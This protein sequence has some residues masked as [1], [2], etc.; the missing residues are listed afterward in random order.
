[1]EVVFWFSLLIVLYTYI[2]YGFTLKICSLFRK[3]KTNPITEE[4]SHPSVAHIVACYN[5]E[6]IIEEKIN[7]CLKLAYPKTKLNTLFVTDGSNDKTVELVQNYQNSITH[8]HENDRKGKLNAVNRVINQVESDIV[9]FSDAN[10]IL[11]KDA[12][13]KIS[14]AFRDPK[15]GAVSGEKRISLEV[16]DDASSS[17]ES[18]YWKYESTLKQLESKVNTVIGAAGELFAIRKN[19]YVSPPSNSLI[20]D[21]ITSVNVAKSGYRVAYEPEA[22]AVEKGSESLEEELKRKVRISAGGIQSIIHFKGL[23]NPIKYGML[24][25]QYIS[26]RV[27]RWT[28]APISLVALFLSNIFLADKS[29]FYFILIICQVCFYSAAILGGLMKRKK[30][31]F[32]LFFV[33]FY[34][35]FMNFSVFMG[36]VKYLK[37]D[38]EVVWEKAKRKE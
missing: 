21:F 7:N 27:M 16:N 19:L 38:Y 32:R 13:I 8:F 12:L 33:P 23:L 15:V 6:S 36:L 35:S 11:N 37:G 34:F 29:T 18:F 25:F 30:I 2:G 20:E 17:G 10:A 26:H 5:E 14:A 24:S 9:V 31:K 22:Y 3:S 1:M 28:I 4:H